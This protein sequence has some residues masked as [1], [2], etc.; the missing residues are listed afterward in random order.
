VSDLQAAKQLLKTAIET[1]DAELIEMA[2]TILAKIKK[3]ANQTK[4]LVTKDGEDFLSPIKKSEIETNKGGVPVNEM[5]E[6]KNEFYDDGTEAKDITTPDFQPTERRRT[7]YKP[8]EQTCQRCNKTFKL[9]PTH[10]REFYTCDKCLG[11]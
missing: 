4:N 1:D 7:P 10:Q 3:P 8:I 2:N 11:K 9:N 5:P 6:R